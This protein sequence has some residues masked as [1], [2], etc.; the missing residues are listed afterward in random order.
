MSIDIG[1][2]A[3]VDT[4]PSVPHHSH[5]LLRQP[6]QLPLQ[7]PW[8]G[9]TVVPANAT[10]PA[11]VMVNNPV[12]PGR[13]YNLLG[14]NIFS[15][16]GH[17]TLA[18]AVADVYFASDGTDLPDMSCQIA[19]G[20]TVPVAGGFIWYSRQVVWAEPGEKLVALVY[21]FSTASAVPLALISRIAE[22][23]LSSKEATTIS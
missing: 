18:S 17:T 9:T 5:R 20:L 15:A 23:P 8:F 14:F 10:L 22:Y 4:N 11:I 3:S 2:E 12:P 13:I 1:F 19:S 21:G 6:E 16:D 7:R